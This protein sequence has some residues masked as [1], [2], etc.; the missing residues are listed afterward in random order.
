VENQKNDI[1][2]KAEPDILARAIAY[3]LLEKKALDVR[4]YNVS[5]D[6]SITSFYVNATGR[7]STNVG[8]L[9]DEV[10]YKIGLS[11]RDELRVEGRSANSWLLIDYGDVIVNI[12][13]RESREFYNFDRLLPENGKV[14]I[15]DIIEELDKKYD[16]NNKKEN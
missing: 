8:A 11:G 10:T 2:S 13:D 7:S 9:A 15:S 6:S 16:I 5:E 1:L 3:I 12:F 14:D 4:I